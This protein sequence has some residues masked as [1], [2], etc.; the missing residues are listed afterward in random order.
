V[1]REDYDEAKRLKAAVDRLKAA[2]GAIAG[3]EARKSA[4]VAEED[5]DLAKQLKQD[6]DR[7]R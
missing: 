3:L 7:M 6:I 1:E 4:A 5:Y 2:G